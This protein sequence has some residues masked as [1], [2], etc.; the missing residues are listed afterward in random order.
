MISDDAGTTLAGLVGERTIATITRPVQV[1]V[2]LGIEATTH[3]TERQGRHGED[4]PIR[5]EE[6]VAAV[7]AALPQVVD[8]HLAG[9]IGDDTGVLISR[10]DGLNVVGYLKLGGREPDFVVV[11]VMRK[12]GFAPKPG[13]WRVS[14]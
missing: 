10:R 14:A 11:T 4:A 7:E 13:T 8:A 1:R 9:R 12:H 3:S 6:I 2:V 5:D